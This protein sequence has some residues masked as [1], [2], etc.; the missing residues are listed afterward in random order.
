MAQTAW[1]AT[2]WLSLA[3]DRRPV[4]G[5]YEQFNGPSGSIRCGEFLTRWKTL[6]YPW[7]Q[8]IRVRV[9]RQDFTKYC[10]TLCGLW[11]FASAFS[12]TEGLQFKHILSS[13]Y[14]CTKHI[15]VQLNEHDK[16]NHW[17]KLHEWFHNNCIFLNTDASFFIS[18]HHSFL[19]NYIRG[20]E[21][22]SAKFLFKY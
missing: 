18:L 11:I 22:V 7:T 6:S 15:S 5:C 16:N 13:F 2:D 21:F 9:G 20:I 12:Q 8:Y 3:Q 4:A 17:K 1:K 19:K 10:E 14:L